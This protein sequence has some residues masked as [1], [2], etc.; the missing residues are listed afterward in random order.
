MSL[1]LIRVVGICLAS[2]VQP[3]H[4][5]QI[6]IVANDFQSGS[7]G[8]FRIQ[9]VSGFAGANGLA[10]DLS[11]DTFQSFCLENG[12]YGGFPDTYD[13]T[14]GTAS[15]AGGA[16]GPSPDPISFATAYL[17]TQFRTGQ[18]SNYSYGATGRLDSAKAL[19]I[20]IWT[21][22]DEYPGG[23][24]ANAQA[25]AWVTEA[26][27]AVSGGSWG[28]TLGL[29]RVLVLTQAGNERQ[30]VLTLIPL[31]AAAWMGIAGLAVL[32]VI[33]ARRRVP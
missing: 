25:A 30:D 3:L 4:G 7:G 23:V 33:R 18:L 10:S 16:G 11:T 22:E 9:T 2:S 8:E 13:Y 28:Q 31:P 27:A 32:P 24:P 17:Y 21:L 12:T 1:H 6:K 14:M 5:D 15:A 20:A 26:L 19:Q 29:V